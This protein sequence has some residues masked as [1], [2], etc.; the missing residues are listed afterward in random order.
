VLFALRSRADGVQV[1][2]SVV[3]TLG[4]VVFG[5]PGF[6]VQPTPGIAFSRTPHLSS[7]MP[8]AAGTFA[9]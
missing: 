4:P 3:A 1:D 2:N 5:E 9:R 7:A 6:G 8:R